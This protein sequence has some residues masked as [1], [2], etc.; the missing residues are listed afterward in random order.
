MIQANILNT[1][2]KDLTKTIIRLLRCA[3]VKKKTVFEWANI[4]ISD[5][6]GLQFVQI[7][8]DE[9]STAYLQKLDGDMHSSSERCRVSASPSST[10]RLLMT[11]FDRTSLTLRPT[12]Q[13]MER[14]LQTC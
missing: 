13:R 14:S 5:K 7:G 10:G 12:G 4:Y 8:D 2:Q 3:L 1:T 6:V 11:Y 9:E